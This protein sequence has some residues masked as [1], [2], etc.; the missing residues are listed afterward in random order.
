[1]DEFISSLCGEL[2][3]R[4]D[5]YVEEGRALLAHQFGA[6]KENLDLDHMKEEVLHIILS[7]I[8]CIFICHGFFF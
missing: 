8:Y 1:M 7:F 2:Y 4:V 5:E 3:Q 6:S